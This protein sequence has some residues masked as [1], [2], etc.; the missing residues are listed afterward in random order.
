MTEVLNKNDL[1]MLDPKKIRLPVDAYGRLQLEIGFEERY[2]PVKALRSLPLT[3]P[4]EFISLQD[5]EGNEVGMIRDLREL[6][7]ESRKAVEEDLELYYLK[8][9]VNAITKVE[10]KNGIITWDLETDLGPKRVHLRDRQN[11]RPLPDGKT[12]LT[13]IHEVKYEI[14]P[15]EELD[16]KSRHWLAIEL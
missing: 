15:M 12:V 11:I 16:E 5:D 13:D 7:P 10:A 9:K 8:A 14:P 3:R 2:G 6:D 4:L 1:R